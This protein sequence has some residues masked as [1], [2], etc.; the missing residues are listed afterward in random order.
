MSLDIGNVF[1]E[2]ASSAGETLQEEGAGLGNDF[3]DVLDNNKDT[4]SELIDARVNGD[5]DEEE[6]ATE[7]EREKL[8]LEAEMLTL[9]IASK[10]AIQ[11]AMNAAMDT[12]SGAIA[13][14]L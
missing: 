5:I 14:A 2:M 13:L 12:L 10:A 9:E 7:M 8:V 3:L 11:K 6:F 4:L 1:K